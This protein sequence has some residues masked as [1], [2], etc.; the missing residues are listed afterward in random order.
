MKKRKFKIFTICLLIIV[1]TFIIIWQLFNYLSYAKS[2]KY[3]Y[4]EYNRTSIVLSLTYYKNLN[5][6]TNSV[7]YQQRYTNEERITK[8]KLITDF[9]NYEYIPILNYIKNDNELNSN[10]ILAFSKIMDFIEFVNY[11]NYIPAE[12]IMKN[13]SKGFYSENNIITVNKKV[14]TKECFNKLFLE[15]INYKDLDTILL[16]KLYNID[17]IRELI[18]NGTN[19]ILDRYV[20]S[21]M[22]FQ[23]S[24]MNDDLERIEFFKWIEKLEFE[25]LELP[26]TDIN[27]FLHMP[28]EKTVELLSKRSEKM[29]GNESDKKYL[30]KCEQT[31]FLIAKKY[32]FKTIECVLNDNIKS[33][34]QISDELYE[35]ILRSLK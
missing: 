35:F 25:H 13:N 28:T 6:F 34:E 17:K 26:R 27:I 18:N 12:S 4:N 9:A 3:L 19:V 14:I 23:G 24:K 5:S 29:D 20:Y 33:I 11:Y 2:Q 30:E 15:F 21:N 32:D 10:M 16:E 31:Y 8:E 22:A 1:L 7:L